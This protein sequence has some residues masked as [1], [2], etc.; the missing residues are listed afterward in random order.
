[1]PSVA[2]A[3]PAGTKKQRIQEL[4]ELVRSRF[5][6][7][8]FKVTPAPDAPGVTA[9]WAYTKGDWEDVEELVAD[10]EFEIMVEDEIQIIVIP[11]ASGAFED[12][13]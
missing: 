12:G 11:Q 9:I 3:R 13:R 2:L 5:G 10:R 7:A 4:K 1:R 8:R 6:D